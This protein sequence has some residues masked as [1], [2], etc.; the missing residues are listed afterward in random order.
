MLGTVLYVWGG[1][2]FLTGGIDELKAR[3]PG[4]ILLIALAI[5]VAF[6]AS[7]GATLHLLDHELTFWWELA[8]LVV[9]I[10]LGHWIEMRSLAQTTSALDSLA[11][12]ASR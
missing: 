10:A 3:R 6:V 7:W 5:T 1:K 2:P 12:V 4:M 9:I 11:A 8:A